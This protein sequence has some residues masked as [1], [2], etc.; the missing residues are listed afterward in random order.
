MSVD[1][2]RALIAELVRRLANL[3]LSP[4]GSGNASMRVGDRIVITPTGG[5]FAMTTPESLAVVDL[6]GS[7]VEDRDDAPRPSKEVPLHVV[8][9]RERPDIHAVVHLHS[10]H[11]TALSVL[12]EPG[13]FAL[14]PH[15]PYG[16][17]R[18]G[19][20]P[21]A[22]YARPGSEAL[23]ESIR[24]V[25][26]GSD[27]VLLGSHGS[28]ALGHRFPDAV[29]LAEEIESAAQV[30]LLLYGRGARTLPDDEVEA[31]RPSDRRPPRIP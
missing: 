28:L 19:G 10:P 31:L 13:T 8:A 30:A 14:E 22:P 29:N 7:H 21:V 6:D 3:G 4:G 11:A 1:L 26:H 9:Y 20:L 2:A 15:T 23:G 27:A 12:A 17:M 5:S 24:D 18:L 25:V 16:V